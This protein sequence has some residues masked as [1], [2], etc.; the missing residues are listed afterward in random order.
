MSLPNEKLLKECAKWI[1]AN[2]HDGFWTPYVLT[3]LNI[4]A[5]DNPHITTDEAFWVFGELSKRRLMVHKIFTSP[6]GELFPA[7]GV[8]EQKEKEWKD[9]AE[10]SGFWRLRFVPW[11][12]W[13]LKRSWLVILFAITVVATNILAEFTKYH[14]KAYLEKPVTPQE[15]HQQPTPPMPK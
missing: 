11:T 7:F 8:N 12:L 1:Y 13:L 4:P 2:K 5:K 6:D 10:K 14:I 9:L 15:I 3:A